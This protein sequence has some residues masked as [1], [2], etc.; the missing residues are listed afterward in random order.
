MTSTAAGPLPAPATSPPATDLA[1]IA[2]G[3]VGVSTSGPL[4][5]ATAV[6]ALAIAFWRNALATAVLAPVALARHRGELQSM[7][8]RTAVLTVLAG[9]LLAAHFAT[10]IPSLRFTS[11]ASATALVATQ[12]L[13]TAVFARLAGHPV[14]RRTWLGMA[15]SL[16]GVV[17]V[18]GVDFSLS[19]RALIGDLL[20]VAGGVL[21]A[22][23]VVVGAEV[24]RTVSTTA[25]TVVCY[26]TC[27]LLLLATCLAARQDLGG[28]YTAEDWWKLVALTVAAQL[29]GHSVFNRVLRTTSPMVVS[30][31]I[32][33]E[34]PGAALLA[35][36]FLGQV[37]PPAALP[38][39][40]LVLAG[41]AVVIRTRAPEEPAAVPVE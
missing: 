36:V 29:L 16:L 24:R 12:V 19:P 15:V 35:A 17:L 32:L 30:L 7:R 8:G 13:W 37:P 9:A 21:A 31:S 14:D 4:M 22:A 2:V 34:V 23:Y 41:L 25:Y 33:L 5:A 3:V 10:W 40:A 39:L 11:V 20:A 6:P 27:S 38:A 28:G 26:G 18:T 1:L